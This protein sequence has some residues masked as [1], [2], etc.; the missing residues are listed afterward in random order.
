MTV[1]YATMKFEI[2]IENGRSLKLRQMRRRVES[3][4][5]YL[6]SATS[7]QPNHERGLHSP[8]VGC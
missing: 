8:I 3:L 4:V 7:T 2:A 1:K 5:R 6:L